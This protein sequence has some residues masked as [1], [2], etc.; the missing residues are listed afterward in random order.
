MSETKSPEK[1][2][3]RGKGRLTPARDL[4]DAMLDRRVVIQKRGGRELVDAP[5]VAGLGAMLVLGPWSALGVAAALLT[6]HSIVVRRRETA[7]AAPAAEET[8][9]APPAAEEP[10]QCQG[11]TKSGSRC[12]LPAQAGSA[13]CHLHG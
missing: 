6:D 10:A 11:V 7:A 4:V 13:Y 1:K 5:L 12:K 8:S 9:L 3:L 2:G